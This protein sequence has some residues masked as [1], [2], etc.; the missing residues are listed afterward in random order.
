MA[1]MPG[2]PDATVQGMA[3]HHCG[4]ADARAQR[5]QHNIFA[6][7]GRATPNFAQECGLRI[8]KHGDWMGDTERALPI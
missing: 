4:A 5:E 2:T 6:A 3:I 8:I 1:E 7:L